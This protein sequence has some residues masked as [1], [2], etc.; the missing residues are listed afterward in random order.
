MRIAVIGAGASGLTCIKCCKDD[1]FEPV[2]FEQEDS[3]G[4]L[5]YFTEEE[6]HSSVYRS[7]VINTSKEMMCFSD[8]PIPRE[9]PPFMHHQWIMK[10]FHIYAAAFDL[11]KHIRYR[12]KVVDLRKA[13]DFEQTGKWEVLFQDLNSKDPEVVKREVYDAVMICAGHHS[14]PS[15]PIFPGMEQ[16]SGI[17]MHSHSYKDFRPFENKN[18]LVVGKSYY[19]LIRKLTTSYLK[20]LILASVIITMRHTVLLSSRY[21]WLSTEERSSPTSANETILTVIYPR[22]DLPSYMRNDCPTLH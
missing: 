20:E 5:W 12:T 2:C 17:K 19:C 14:E 21:K 1:G 3:I 22:D 13:A 6:R 11:Y 7:T 8:F 4:G 16:F 10:Y 15:W 18:V 9:Y